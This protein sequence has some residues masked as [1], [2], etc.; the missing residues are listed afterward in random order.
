MKSGETGLAMR[1]AAF[2]MLAL[3]CRFAGNMVIFIVIARLPGIGTAEFGQLTYGFSLATLFVMLS[4]FGLAPLVIRNIAADASLLP[5]YANSVLS[6]RIALSLAGAAAMA[7]YLASIGME[8]QGLQVCCIIALALS[9]GAF[10]TDIQALFQGREKMHLELLGIVTENLLLLLMGL[11]AYFF[12]PNIVKVAFIFLISKSVALL[13]NYSLCGRLLLRL[14]PHLNFREWK[15]MLKEAAPFA[16]TSILAA[17]VVQIDTVLMRELIPG[18]SEA[19]V[20]MYQAAVRLFLIP[21]LLP[22]II[23]KVFLPQLSRMHGLFGSGLVRDLGRVN[24]VLLTLGL[25]IGIVTLFRGQD[26]IRAI[27]GEAYAG[28]GPILQIL[29]ISI[30]MRF[31]AAYSLYFTIRN[32]I[33]FRVYSALLALVTLVIADWVLIPKYGPIGAAYASVIAHAVYWVPYLIAIFMA[34]RTISLGWNFVRAAGASA[35][36]AAFLYG[37][38]DL[39]IFY[40][41]PIYGVSVLAAVFATMPGGDRIRIVSQFQSKVS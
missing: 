41:M 18:D 10:S 29:G 26:L 2:G 9:I 38:S 40:M 15:E 33:W 30:I 19:A 20:G 27:Y 39:S 7:L 37:T 16:I 25:L 21:M 3:G 23:L 8:T 17:G 14:R 13:F 12:Q 35:L 28:A 22:E 11:A 36:L 32:R 6:L 31:G 1:N 34:E 24:N 4:Q 5:G